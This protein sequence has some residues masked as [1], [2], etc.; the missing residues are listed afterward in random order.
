M[1]GEEFN[2]D[3]TKQLREILFEKLDIPVLKKTP[4]GQAS[5]AE[6]VMQE[7]SEHYPIP[8]L[9]LEFRSYS[10]LKSTYTDKLPLQV[11]PKTGRIHTNYIQ[12]GTSTGRLASKDPNLQNN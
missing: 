2:I 11:N 5:T 12:T 7:L 3:S 1:A 8:K 9:I 10:K 4:S 6:D